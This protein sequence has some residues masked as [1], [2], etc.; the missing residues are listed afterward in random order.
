M[1]RGVYQRQKSPCPECG[2]MFD[3]TAM[4]RHRRLAHQGHRE[5]LEQVRCDKCGGSFSSKGLHNHY[6]HCTGQRPRRD[7]VV[8]RREQLPASTE[9]VKRQYNKSGWTVS[10]VNGDRQIA[11]KVSNE[12]ARRIIG[13]LL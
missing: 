6:I 11:A 4:P 3:Q 12:T 2:R 13:M 9:P 7:S 10:L 1:P 8:E 5:V